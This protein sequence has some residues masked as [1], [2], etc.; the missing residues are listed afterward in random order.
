MTDSYSSS[1]GVTTCTI[2]RKQFRTCELYMAHIDKWHIEGQFKCQSLGC[3]FVASYRIDLNRHLKHVHY[4]T[5]R[6]KNHPCTW[7]DCPK[8]FS[9]LT[10]LK[11]HLRVHLKYKKYRCKWPECTYASEQDSNVI[12]H[13]RIRH[14]K[15]PIT[16]KEQIELNISHDKNPHDF[17]E[18]MPD[19]VV[20]G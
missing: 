8:L 3:E 13:I 10:L 1:Y 12:R 16:V 2:C 15:L 11:N 18:V 19:D 4:N 9:S 7:P 5:I 17:M 20:I 6:P 14:F